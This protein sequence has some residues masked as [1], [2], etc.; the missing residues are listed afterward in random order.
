MEAKR[1]ILSLKGNKAIVFD[2]FAHFVQKQWC[3]IRL[4]LLVVAYMYLSCSTFRYVKYQLFFN[5]ILLNNLNKIGWYRCSSGGWKKL[6]LDVEMRLKWVRLDVE[7]GVGSPSFVFF[8]GRFVICFLVC[9]DFLRY[10][11][12]VVCE[13]IMLWF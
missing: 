2:S 7:M 11:L 12:F 8:A 1:Y 13:R 9:C 10:L 5:I 4:S 6:D 3:L